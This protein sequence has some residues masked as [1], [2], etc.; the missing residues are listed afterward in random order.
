VNFDVMFG[1][2]YKGI[3]LSAIVCSA[4]YQ[5]YGVNVDYAFNRKEDKF[6]GEG[7]KI[8]GAP[9]KDQ[10]VL[11]IDDVI[12]AGTAIRET[13][14]LLTSVNAIPMGV[15]I[16]LDRAEIRSASDT[17]SAVQ[18]VERD[19]SIPVVSIVTLVELQHFLEQSSEYDASTLRSVV[20]YRKEYGAI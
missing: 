7:G 4:L 6:H 5:Q 9:L 13:V 12:T 8:V 20:N 15:I 16:A 17:V 14:D 10:R 2:A 1:P 3:P 19:L 11:I 18:A